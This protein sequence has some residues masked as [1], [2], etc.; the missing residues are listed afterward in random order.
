MRCS[1]SFHTFPLEIE[2]SSSTTA[3]N[4]AYCRLGWMWSFPFRRPAVYYLEH[5]VSLWICFLETEE[6]RV[7][8]QISEDGLLTPTTSYVSWRCM[9]RTSNFRLLRCWLRDFSGTSTPENGNAGG[10]AICIHRDILF[11]EA[12]VTHLVTCHGRDHLVNI[13]SGRHN[14]IIVNIHIEAY[15]QLTKT[16]FHPRFK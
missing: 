7:Q 1:S 5:Q 3:S 12:I 8:T 10:S 15:L 9:E 2:C 6:H 16:Q 11:D 14:L 4:T 13:E